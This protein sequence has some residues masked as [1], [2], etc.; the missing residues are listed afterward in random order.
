MG[1]AP[2][3]IVDSSAFNISGSWSTWGPPLTSYYKNSSIFLADPIT[4][5]L[6]GNIGNFSIEIEA[7]NVQ[8][9]FVGFSDG[10][11]SCVPDTFVFSSLS[12]TPLDLFEVPQAAVEDN[13]IMIPPPANLPA[14]YQINCSV[15]PYFNYALITPAANLS[16]NN[17]LLFVNYTDITIVSE[18]QWQDLSTG[19]PG[20]SSGMSGTVVKFP[21]TVHIG[22]N[23]T[24]L[25]LFNPSISGNITLGVS[26]DEEPKFQLEFIG[27]MQDQP[28]FYYFEYFTLVQES[29]SGNHT[30][31]IEVLEASLFQTFAFRGSTYVPGFATLDDMPDLSVL[32]S[33]N[34]PTVPTPSS[35]ST[36]SL[37]GP[38]PSSQQ[39]LHGGA[40]AG[41]VVGAIAAI[42]LIELIL[43]AAWQQVKRR[44]SPASAQSWGESMLASDEHLPPGP[45]N[46]TP[47]EKRIISDAPADM[48]DMTAANAHGITPFTKSYIT[49]PALE[50]V[51]D[52]DTAHNQEYPVHRS[53]VMILPHG[54]DTVNVPS[55]SVEP[56]SNVS[57]GDNRDQ[58]TPQEPDRTELLL[59]RLNNFDECHPT[60][61]CI[62]IGS[63]HVL[64][65][66]SQTGHWRILM[67]YF[68]QA[69]L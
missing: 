53:T 67:V 48:N 41:V 12:S 35:T 27:G 60:T 9:S 10:N 5:K 63:I 52:T 64:G 28:P 30:I 16:L 1:Q 49:L 44:R 11:T 61:P 51:G 13:I 50:T 17:L 59:E 54:E 4:G 66:E 65:R 43:W 26:L 2:A 45:E 14:L 19:S 38:G 56:P 32:T 40:I 42:C 6:T 58:I 29:D 33:S 8:M 3:I 37:G 24:L 18:G 21:F 36:G 23:I 22:W 15:G 25:G 31:A 34:S 47:F 46:V 68:G 39:G 57:N 69:R 55:F 62:W 7:E 20:L